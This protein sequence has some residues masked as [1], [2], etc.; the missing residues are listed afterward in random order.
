M[1]WW[2]KR[3]ALRV[4]FQY[5]RTDRGV[6]NGAEEGECVP[7]AVSFSILERI[8]VCATKQLERFVPNYIT[9]SILERIVVCATC[10]QLWKC[11]MRSLS[12]SSNGSW[13]VQPVCSGEF[14]GYANV[15]Q[16]PRTDRGVCNL[17]TPSTRQSED[18]LS[19]SSN[20][21]WCVQPG[22]R[23]R[24]AQRRARFQYPR[25]DRGVCNTVLLVNTRKLRG[26]SV[27]SNGSWCVQR[28]ARGNVP[29][30][31]NLSVSS[32]GSWCVQQLLQ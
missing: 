23:H 29:P 22:G 12:V 26:L 9:F 16:Y 21:S 4:D 18:C 10:L 2:G 32:N 1:W 31:C 15:F 24:R 3:G 13:C 30:R 27:S 25:T 19:V 6:C 17:V 20:G 7:G 28:L 5:P 14:C 11:G 8:V